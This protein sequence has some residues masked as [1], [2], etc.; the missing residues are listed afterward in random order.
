PNEVIL[1]VKYD[2]YLPTSI[3]LL[4]QGIHTRHEAYSKYQL[5]RMFG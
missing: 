3:K 4:L 5:S 1:E 2:S